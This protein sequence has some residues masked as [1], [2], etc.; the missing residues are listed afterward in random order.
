MELNA[1]Y[2]TLLKAYID[3][4]ASILYIVHSLPLSAPSVLLFSTPIIKYPQ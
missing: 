2:T 3:V 4:P 1:A